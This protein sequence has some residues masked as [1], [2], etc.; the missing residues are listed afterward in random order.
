MHARGWF[1]NNERVFEIIFVVL[2]IMGVLGDIISPI[3]SASLQGILK[4]VFWVFG[5]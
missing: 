4:L 3:I 5:I 2:W 1:E